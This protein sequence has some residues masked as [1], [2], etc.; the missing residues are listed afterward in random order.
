[1]AYDEALAGRVRGALASRT[2]FEEK[3]MFGGLA[4]MVNTHM[5]CGSVRDDLLVRVGKE[6]H[7][8][9]IAR[10]AREMDVTGR[11]MRGMVVVPGS[12][13]TT[14]KALDE[15]VDQAV[16]FAR[17]DPAKPPKRPR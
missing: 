16:A 10:G 7:E 17:S 1:M 8:A 12:A 15:W 14:D 3:A 5:A 4:F 13:L 11:P 9:A 6:N 2:D